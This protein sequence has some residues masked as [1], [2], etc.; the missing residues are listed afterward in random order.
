VRPVHELESPQMGLVWEN[1]STVACT[2]RMAALTEEMNE[3]K[4]LDII[5]RWLEVLMAEA[6]EIAPDARKTKAVETPAKIGRFV[7]RKA[8]TSAQFRV[9]GVGWLSTNTTES[10]SPFGER[11]FAHFCDKNIVSMIPKADWF[12]LKALRKHAFQKQDRQNQAERPFGEHRS[13]VPPTSATLAQ[14]TATPKTS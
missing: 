13:R 14:M 2:I 8:R 9:A 10:R 11:V 12:L 3:V 6:T 7:W 5:K 4:R 1:R